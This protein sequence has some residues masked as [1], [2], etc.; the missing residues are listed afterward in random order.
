MVAKKRIPKRIAGVKLNKQLRKRGNEL[1]DLADSP[2][3]RE[4]IA[5]GLSMAAAAASVAIRKNHAPAPAAT[6]AAG[7]RSAPGEVRHDPAPPLDPQKIVEAVGQTIETAMARFF[8]AKK[9]P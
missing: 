2:Q 7:D 9:A 1:L 3:G 4:T 6:P 8:A 5:M